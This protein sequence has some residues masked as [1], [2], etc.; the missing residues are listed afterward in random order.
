MRLNIWQLYAQILEQKVEEIV[1][2]STIYLLAPMET[3]GTHSQ[4][5]PNFSTIG[6]RVYSTVS[7]VPVIE[8]RGC[9]E[10][11]DC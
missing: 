3:I 2:T 7:V 1:R 5:Q 9:L 8:L 10:S 4:Q 6:G 11:I